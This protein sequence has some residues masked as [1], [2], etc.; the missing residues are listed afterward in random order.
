MFYNLGF[1]DTSYTM[2]LCFVWSCEFWQ[3]LRFRWKHILICT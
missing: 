3:L 2:I 1:G